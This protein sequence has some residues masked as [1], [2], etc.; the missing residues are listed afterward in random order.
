MK[1]EGTVRFR[2]YMKSRRGGGGGAVSI[3][4]DTRGGGGRGCV[5]YT[6]GTIQKAGGGVGL[7]SGRGG[8]TLYE[9][10]TL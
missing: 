7:L 2:P 9:R 8:G 3:R 10:T 1:R 4:P 6:S 5:L